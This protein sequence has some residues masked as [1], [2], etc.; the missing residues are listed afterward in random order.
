MEGVLLPTE[1]ELDQY[2]VPRALK[3]PICIT[4]LDDPVQCDN[5]HCFCLKCITAAIPSNASCPVCRCAIT[6]VT[7][8]G[9]PSYMKDQIT[10]VVLTCIEG[11]DCSFTGTQSEMKKH[12][13]VCRYRMV[14]CPL[15]LNDNLMSSTKFADHIRCVHFDTNKEVT[16]VD[17][18][19]NVYVD[20]IGCIEKHASSCSASFHV[21]PNA[22]GRFI[23]SVGNVKCA[24]NISSFKDGKIMLYSVNTD[25]NGETTKIHAKF[26]LTSD[27]NVSFRYANCKFSSKGEL[28]DQEKWHG[29]RSLICKCPVQQELPKWFVVTATWTDISHVGH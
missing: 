10:K 17:N 29:G 12:I 23:F 19:T 8:R 16:D 28:F 24:I 25:R 7:L 1:P 6:L 21:H 27:S 9:V 5:G 22:D 11:L 2:G 18:I 13:K 3:C 20:L 4:L 26:T 15:C 14:K